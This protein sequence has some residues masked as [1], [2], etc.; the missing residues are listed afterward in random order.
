MSNATPI[1]VPDDLVY[2][3]KIATSRVRFCE[4]VHRLF[5]AANIEQY[6]RE[7]VRSFYQ[8]IEELR[9][10]LEHQ[11]AAGNSAVPDLISAAREI[12]PNG[13]EF[14]G[15]YY[16]TAHHCANVLG[17]RAKYYWSGLKKTEGDGVPPLGD[18][19]ETHHT[20]S[21]HLFQQ[22]TDEGGRGT[23]SK[24]TCRI[25]QET[26]LAAERREKR[27]AAMAGLQVNKESE[28]ADQT[29]RVPMAPT[30]VLPPKKED[31]GSTR[32]NKPAEKTAILRHAAV[33]SSVVWCLLEK[34]GYDLVTGTLA[35]KAPVRQKEVIRFV[36]KTMAVDTSDNAYKSAVSKSFGRLFSNLDKTGFATYREYCKTDNKLR[37]WFRTILDQQPAN[38]GTVGNLQFNSD[39]QRVSGQ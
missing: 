31:R 36:K 13:Y 35:K 17:G 16:P 19:R 37:Q 22:L 7:A 24:L 6:D 20:V 14:L 1:Q 23:L 21:G 38:S 28:P 25:E 12:D 9:P 32:E 34:H 3:C 11:M 4:A 10:I 39:D 30:I 26:A 8:E 5:M 27:S 2:C 15:E 33:D 18:I 29:K